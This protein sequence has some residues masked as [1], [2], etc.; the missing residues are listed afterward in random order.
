MDPLDGHYLILHRPL[1]ADH[2]SP[3]RTTLSACSDLL[4]SCDLFLSSHFL[5]LILPESSPSF[6]LSSSLHHPLH[7]S[8]SSSG[9]LFLSRRVELNFPPSPSIFLIALPLPRT[10]TSTSSSITCIMASPALPSHPGPDHQIT[11][12]VLYN[13]SNRRFKLPL[14]ELQPQVL[15]QKVSYLVSTQ[16][17]TGLEVRPHSLISKIRSVITMLDHPKD[18]WIHAFDIR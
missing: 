11:I 17:P 18:R 13:D 12:K 4:F 10:S 15:P 2:L 9:L 16:A 3:H 7:L 6:V 1:A 8:R 14:K 5:T